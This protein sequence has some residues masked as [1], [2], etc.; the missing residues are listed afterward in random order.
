MIPPLWTKRCG[1]AGA[2]STQHRR[3]LA[4]SCEEADQTSFLERRELEPWSGGDWMR[5]TLSEKWR[6]TACCDSRRGAR[7]EASRCPGNR[8][9]TP[10][11]STKRSEIAMRELLVGST[12][13]G[14]HTARCSAVR[15]TARRRDSGHSSPLR[16]G[17]GWI[18]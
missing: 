18:C 14:L 11:V 13:G 1:G 12:T 10:P 3:A 6:P 7:S 8:P 15:S 4:C 5:A 17:R 2:G 9:H 16:L